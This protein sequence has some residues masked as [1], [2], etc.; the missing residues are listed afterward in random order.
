VSGDLGRADAAQ[1]SQHLD[2]FVAHRAGVELRGRLHRGQAQQLQQVVLQH[3]AHRPGFVV[4]VAAALDAD[5]LGHGDL[6]LGDVARVPQRL[7][8]RVAEAQRQQVLHALLAEVVVDPEHAGLVEHAGH[9]VVD[10]DRALEVVA[11]RLFQQHARALGAEAHRAEG[12]AGRRVEARG[13]GQVVD[14]VAVAQRQ[15]A[16]AERAHAGF[17]DQGAEACVVER[18]ARGAEDAQ[19]LRQQAVALQAV[20]RG[21]QHALREVAGG[22]EDHQ[23]GGG[24]VGHGGAGVGITL[25]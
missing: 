20:Q 10:R 14:D 18:A 11:D 15:D 21:Q 8:Q 16:L 4:V 5:R 13:G 6:H 2:L 12:F 9:A 1:R 22:A 17:R 23:Q 3:V 25:A 19:P 7:E 24:L